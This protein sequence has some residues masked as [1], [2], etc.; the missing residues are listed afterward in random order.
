MGYVA[1]LWEVFPYFFLGHLLGDYVF[2]TGYIARHKS[3]RFVV[4]IG[5]ALI[6]FCCQTASLMGRN[7]GVPQALSV[8]GLSGLHLGIDLVKKNCHTTFCKS[9]A[10]YLIDQGVHVL[11]FLP[12]VPIFSAVRFFIERPVTVVASVMIFNAYFIG[13]LVHLMTSDREYRR[14]YAGYVLRMLAPVSYHISRAAFAVYVFAMLLVV[15]R[16]SRKRRSVF[17]DYVFSTTSTIILMEVM[18]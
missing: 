7:F 14:D 2:Q 10:Y 4:L 15:I 1:E 18:L 3:T 11:S 6:I 8:I 9:W 12:F 16:Y 13:I 17:L 5:H